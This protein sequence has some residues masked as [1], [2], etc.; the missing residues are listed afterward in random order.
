[1]HD[2]EDAGFIGARFGHSVPPPSNHGIVL[3]RSL[4]PQA[5]DR[6]LIDGESKL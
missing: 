4:T 6:G 3:R 1:M 2:L 5:Q